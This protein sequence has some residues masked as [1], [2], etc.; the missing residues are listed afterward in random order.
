[1]VWL[2][3]AISCTLAVASVFKVAGTRGIDVVALCTINYLIAAVLAFATTLMGG[4]T[5]GYTTAFLAT[6][7]TVGAFFVGSFLVFG[8]AV[9][10][11]GLGISVAVSRISAVVPVLLAWLIWSERPSV[12]AMVGLGLA[13]VAVVLLTRATPEGK[14]ART[15]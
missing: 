2:I 10:Q 14:A 7:V 15:S 6:A 13:M 4:H 1:M 11:A 9:A 12:M 8:V 3:L 5:S